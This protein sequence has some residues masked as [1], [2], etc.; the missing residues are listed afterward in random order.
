M[1]TGD[2]ISYSMAGHRALYIA[3]IVGWTP[4]RMKVAE[5][6][7]KYNVSK[8]STNLEHHNTRFIKISKMLIMQ[9]K[10][11]MNLSKMNKE[12]LEDFHRSNI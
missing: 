4:K 10:M 8:Y 2:Y 12:E 11:G 9:L 3:K 5:L 7:K 6:N 1:H